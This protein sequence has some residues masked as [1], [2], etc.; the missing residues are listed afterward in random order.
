MKNNHVYPAFRMARVGE[1][2]ITF[3][4]FAAPHSPGTALTKKRREVH[5]SQPTGDN[6]VER[7]SSK[8]QNDG[9]TGA[10]LES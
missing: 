9:F 4:Q 7:H 10:E 6:L 8:T 5:S 3:M 1:S 2:S